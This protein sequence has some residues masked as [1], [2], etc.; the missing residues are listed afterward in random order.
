MNHVCF[1]DRAG[2]I[3]F[4]TRTPKGCLTIAS[5]GDREALEAAVGPPARLAYDN[6]T[7]LVPGIPEADS[8]DDALEALLAFRDQVAMRLPH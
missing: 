8:D 3:E 7:L 4:G 1:A 5:H 2:V 6:K